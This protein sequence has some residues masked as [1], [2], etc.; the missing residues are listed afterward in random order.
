MPSKHVSPPKFIDSSSEYAGYKRKLLRWSRI[1]D[2]KANKQAEHVVHHLEDHPS[3]IQEK[4]EIKLGDEIVDKDDGM[5]KLI[6]YLDSIYGED[7]LTDVWTKYKEFVH[8]E[9]IDNQPINEFIADYEKTY[10]KSKDSGCEFSDIV[11][12]LN[13]L[14]SSKL[15]ETD[16]KF[17]L[18][19]I[20]FKVAKEKKDL[21]E[22]VKNSLKKF[23]S[24]NKLYEKDDLKMVVKKEESYVS[25]EDTEALIAQGWKPP[26]NISKKLAQGSKGKKNF[27]GPDGKPK[28]CY[29]CQSEYHLLDKCPK[30]KRNDPKKKEDE[31]KDD[32]DDKTEP[33]M[34]STLMKRS[35]KNS[36][37]EYG[38]MCIVSDGNDKDDDS[39]SELV[40]V[41]HNEEEL[42]YLVEEAGNRG[43]LDSACS[44]TVAGI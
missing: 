31:D 40:L 3:N 13:L 5:T 22:Q 19:G 33:T 35:G 30:R 25:S 24:R 2:V 36:K 7:E 39:E 10:M 15:S 37:A 17:V 11:L 28:R 20:D 21:F 41:T 32:K 8:L 12:G 1:T 16:E 43:V 4:I 44:K 23:Q 9:K 14:D 27:E 26:Q 38:M 34:L 42:C 6:E 18:T 29:G